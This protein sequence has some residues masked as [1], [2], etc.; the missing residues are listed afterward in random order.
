MRDALCGPTSPGGRRQNRTVRR[1]RRTLPCMYAPSLS[2]LPP[3]LH[4]NMLT[5]LLRPLPQ[6]TRVQAAR[7]LLSTAPAAPHASLSRSEGGISF[8]T[9]DRPAA[10]N[11]LSVQLVHE[12]RAALDEVRFDG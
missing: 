6:A 9:L 5:L 4:S 3:L 7:R 8:L 1:A 10:K 11:S 2:L 12:F